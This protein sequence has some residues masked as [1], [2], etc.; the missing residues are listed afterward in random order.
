MYKVKITDGI[1]TKAQKAAEYKRRKANK[2]KQLM[3]Q[4]YA[5][6]ADYLKV[7]SELKNGLHA[8]Q[9]EDATAWMNVCKEKAVKYYER[10]EKIK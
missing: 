4:A 7:K 10:A 9:L 6:K 1:R 5:W 3:D 8:D 2:I